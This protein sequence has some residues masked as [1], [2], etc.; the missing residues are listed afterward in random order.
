MVDT[1]AVR[2]QAGLNHGLVN[3]HGRG[4]GTGEKTWITQELHLYGGKS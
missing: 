1:P 3:S 2:E 4:P